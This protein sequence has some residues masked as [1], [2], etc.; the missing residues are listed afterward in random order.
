MD[1]AHDTTIIGRGKALVDTDIQMM[2]PVG[3]C[4]SPLLSHLAING[5]LI[6]FW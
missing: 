4:M 1:S 5:S 6:V 2:I 3:T